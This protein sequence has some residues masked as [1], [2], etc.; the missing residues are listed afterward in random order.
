MLSTILLGL[1]F[2]MSGCGSGA[3]SEG[4]LTPARNIAGTW[5]AST[6]A[7][8]KFETD[9][10]TS[11]LSLVASQGWTVALDIRAGANEN[12]V[13]VAMSFVASGSEIVSGCPG[14][15]VVPEVSPMFLTGNVN[16]TRLELRSGTTP[17]A[18]FNFTT[19]IMTGVLDYTWCSVYCQREYTEA[20]AIVLRRQ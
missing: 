9:F 19:D 13:A 10:C 16:G 6:P 14:T 3:D 12:T 20:N 5:T 1:T 11:D 17:V 18:S 15:G 8:V 4:P 7:M 2:V